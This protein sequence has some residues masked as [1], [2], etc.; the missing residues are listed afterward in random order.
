[1]SGATALA[2]WTHR[3]EILSSAWRYV[4]L[5]ACPLYFGVST[6]FK[7]TYTLNLFETGVSA[8]SLL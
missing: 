4:G 7:G 6:K 2:V 3:A 8:T 1:M 5:A